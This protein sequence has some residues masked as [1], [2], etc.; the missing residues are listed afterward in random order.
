M[1]PPE[2]SSGIIYLTWD[3]TTNGLDVMFGINY[4][5][6]ADDLADSKETLPPLQS[7]IFG[8]ESVQTEN[9]FPGNADPS[10]VSSSPS[11]S[12]PLSPQ[13]QPSSSNKADKSPVPP[14]KPIRR[15][16]K[17]TPSGSPLSDRSSLA[18]RLAAAVAAHEQAPQ[19]SS[20][21]APAVTGE[22]RGNDLE[23][24]N[25]GLSEARGVP[26]ETQSK[27]ESGQF[28][29]TIV[30]PQLNISESLRKHSRTETIIPSARVSSHK[31]SSLSGVIPISGR[32][33]VYSFV[34]DNSHSVVL[35]K[36]IAFRVGT[37]T[38]PDA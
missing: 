21:G 4:S 26:M 22:L 8:V 27:R 14:P 32:Y 36:T 15:N 29:Q 17:A 12:A 37:V 13:L 1:D 23:C 9:S 28:L 31:G 3:Y 24:D 30:Q 16:Q 18:S 6:F 19:P 34:W 25:G 33:G 5:K 38:H 2:G 7:E 35:H 10:E 11:I 20:D